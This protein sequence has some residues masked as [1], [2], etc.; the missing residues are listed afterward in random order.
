MAETFNGGEGRPVIA[1][2]TAGTIGEIKGFIVDSGATRIDSVHVAGRGRKADLISWSAIRSFGA[3][4]VMAELADAVEQV[5]S[6]HEKHAVK[7]NIVA[8]ET[9]VLDTDG[10]E[11]GTVED[12]MF[13]ADTGL[14]TGALTTEGRVD[15]SRFRSLGSYALVV[16]AQ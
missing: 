15:S 12:V 9:R 7:G 11:R 16:D 1:A 4:A 10:F 14:L 5:S 6:D 13:D 2:D 8:R 3:D